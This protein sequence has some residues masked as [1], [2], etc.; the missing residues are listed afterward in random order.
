[1][2]EISSEHFSCVI[3]KIYQAMNDQSYISE[4][5]IIEINRE[6]FMYQL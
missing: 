1:M 5:D 6:H 3:S 2:G 4:D